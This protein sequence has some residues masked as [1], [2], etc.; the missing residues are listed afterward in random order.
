MAKIKIQKLERQIEKEL[1]N[2]FLND[3]KDDIGFITV[4]G[5]D[6]TNDLSYAKI[7]YTVLGNDDKKKAVAKRLEN[8]KGFIR[9]TLG[10][11]VQM[12]K[13]PELIFVYDQSIEY[14]NKIEELIEKIN[15]KEKS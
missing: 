6:L 11:R 4:T 2:I 5:V 12:R 1:A 13:L 3:V 7:Y 14:G 8:A 9:T 10:T 15:E